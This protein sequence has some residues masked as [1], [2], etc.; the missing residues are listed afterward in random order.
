MDKLESR[1]GGGLHSYKNAKQFGRPLGRRV[2]MRSWIQTWRYQILADEA[3]AY[4]RA[5]RDPTQ[6]RIFEEL[7][8]SYLKLAA[9]KPPEPIP[10][11]F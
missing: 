6:K 8:N 11:A 9:R 3:L 5:L 1:L 10:V 2:N 7:A 4:A